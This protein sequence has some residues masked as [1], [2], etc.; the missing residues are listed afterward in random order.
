MIKDDFQIIKSL[1]KRQAAI[2]RCPHCHSVYITEQK[3]DE[4]G[5]NLLYTRWGEPFGGKSL[6]GIRARYLD[7]IDH[8]TRQ[9][10]V[11]ENK[12]SPLGKEYRRS[13]ENRFKE[14]LEYFAL[15]SLDQNH[16]R[17]EFYAEAKELILEMVD[18][19]TNPDL[20]DLWMEEKVSDELMTQ[21]HFI[22]QNA[23]KADLPKT[24][25]E[26]IYKSPYI[27][28]VPVMKILTLFAFMT[29]AIF[30]ILSVAK[31]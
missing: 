23:A 8:L 24:V 26:R 6:W 27:R 19:G 2:Q 14:L 7:G 30:V 17:T 11:L 16:H 28:I 22:A 31:H 4:C 25:F 10:P 5:R 15:T 12:L 9:F 29:A 21:F 18:Y 3:C 1:P 13:L 20:I